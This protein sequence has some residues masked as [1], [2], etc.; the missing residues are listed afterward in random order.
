MTKA[1]E[2]NIKNTVKILMQLDEK[3]LLLVDSGARLLAA[4]QKMDRETADNNKQL[5]K[6]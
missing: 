6:T 1:K 4:R 5:L 2:D 3:S